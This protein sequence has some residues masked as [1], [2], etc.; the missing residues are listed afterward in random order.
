[1]TASR[2][3]TFL[4]LLLL[5]PGVSGCAWS[6]RGVMP[7]ESPSPTDLL[8]T[9]ND[10]TLNTSTAG[11]AL[12]A[13]RYPELHLVS[14]SQ[15]SVAVSGPQDKADRT[16]LTL[17]HFGESLTAD[18]KYF[19]LINDKPRGFM[20]SRFTLA[21]L[22]AEKIITPEVLAANY[23]DQD[24]RNIAILRD[25]LAG[26]RASADELK[27]SDPRTRASSMAAQRVLNEI[28]T[29]LKT[30]PAEA[31]RFP[32]VEGM[33]FNDSLMGKGRLR[34]LIDGDVARLKI[35][36]GNASDNFATMPDVQNM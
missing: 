5:V 28:L 25:V 27:L 13:V 19:F 20:H 35:I 21:R 10:I 1:M 17:V 7:Q 12:S 33:P 2:L 9:F 26:F 4:A 31:S 14:Q 29:M 24:A 36:V 22:D 11:D 23:P 34:M 3:V 15:N 6:V 32:D 16:W 30:A 18:G 8:V